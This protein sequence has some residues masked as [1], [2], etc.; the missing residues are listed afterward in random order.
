MII[1]KV[2]KYDNCVDKV[3]HHVAESS[4]SLAVQTK[5]NFK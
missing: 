4:C 5:F 3:S 2:I 1:F